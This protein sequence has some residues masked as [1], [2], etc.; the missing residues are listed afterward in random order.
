M[1]RRTRG[2]RLF[3]QPLSVFFKATPLFYL[4]LQ[5]PWHPYFSCIWW[6]PTHSKVGFCMIWYKFGPGGLVVCRVCGSTVSL[7]SLFRYL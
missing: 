2:S 5:W 7:M 3:M 1:M 6:T 4:L